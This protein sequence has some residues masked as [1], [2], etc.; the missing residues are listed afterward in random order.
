[1]DDRAGTG[2]APPAGQTGTVYGAGW[3]TVILGLLAI[4]IVAAAWRR[5]APLWTAAIPGL[6][7]AVLVLWE[8]DRISRETSLQTFLSAQWRAP[9]HV[10]DGVWVCLAGALAAAGCGLAGLDRRGR[11]RLG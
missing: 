1:M 3:I 5:I 4:A 7:A 9:V 8:A 2:V 10:G 11:R 6:A